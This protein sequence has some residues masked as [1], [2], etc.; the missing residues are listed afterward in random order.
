MYYIQAA[1]RSIL[2]AT[3]ASNEV[4][5]DSDFDYYSTFKGFQKVMLNK[6]QS[7]LSL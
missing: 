7:I 5:S 4:P 1:F 3:K 6:G 2:A